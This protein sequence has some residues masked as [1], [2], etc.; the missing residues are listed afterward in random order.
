MISV[1]LIPLRA[2]KLRII[3]LKITL[4]SAKILNPIFLF[5]GNEKK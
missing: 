4:S 3:P 2:A 1:Q 5:G